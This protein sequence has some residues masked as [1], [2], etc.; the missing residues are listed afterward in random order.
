MEKFNS[1][2]PFTTENIAGYME[3]LSLTNKKVMTVTGS[4]D[5]ILNAIVRGATDIT[6]FDINPKAEYY[7]HLK[8]SAIARLTYEE[9]CEILLYDTNNSF[10]PSTITKLQMPLASQKFWK[11][12]LQENKDNGLSLKKSS[13]FTRTYFSPEKT[14]KNNLYLEKDSYQYLQEKLSSVKITFINRNIKDLVLSQDYDYLFLSNIADYLSYM[15]DKEELLTYKKLLTKLNEKITTIY[16]AYLYDI[17]NNHPRSSIDQLDKV[18]N[19]FPNMEIK[20]FPSCLEPKDKKKKD[21]VLI[22][23]KGEKKHV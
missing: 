12:E 1:I 19:L 22:L 14:K 6:T 18:S 5:H 20:T 8:T 21:G 15:Y 9:F 3:E 23:T 13:L 17:D 11:K 4:T 7:L 16:F 2:Y 10:H